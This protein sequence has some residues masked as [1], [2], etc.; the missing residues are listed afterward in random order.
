M[1]KNYKIFT[2]DYDYYGDSEEQER[3]E[4]DIGDKLGNWLKKNWKLIAA[5]GAGAAA[6]FAANKLGE[7][8]DSDKSPK[9]DDIVDAQPIYYEEPPKEEKKSGSR[10][11]QIAF[12]AGTAAGGALAGS[13]W[14]KIMST[15]KK[16]SK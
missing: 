9:K 13:Q 2:E 7:K 15:I 8:K 3:P 5:G 4:E 6:V 12:G 14:D 16:I 1:N 11:K 10:L